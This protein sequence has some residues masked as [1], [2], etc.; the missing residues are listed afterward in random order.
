MDVHKLI[1]FVK[2]MGQFTT[3]C[4]VNTRTASYFDDDYVHN[5]RNNSTTNC[6]NNV[7]IVTRASI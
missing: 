3:P 7:F 4:G 6:S 5:N 1:L 2:N